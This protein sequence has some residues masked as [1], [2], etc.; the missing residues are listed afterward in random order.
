[1]CKSCCFILPNLELTFLSYGE[2]EIEF[3]TIFSLNCHPLF[4]SVLFGHSFFYL[5]VLQ[6]RPAFRKGSKGNQASNRVDE[7]G[8]EGGE[9]EETNNYRGMMDDRS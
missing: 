1:M 7:R 4:F 3:F 9:E 8:G 6:I 5:L 2:D